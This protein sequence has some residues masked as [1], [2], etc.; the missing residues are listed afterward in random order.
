MQPK[1]VFDHLFR[2]PE[3]RRAAVEKVRKLMPA[4][5]EVG[6]SPD[7]SAYGTEGTTE[8]HQYF[9]LDENKTSTCPY[10]DLDR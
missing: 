5:D 7:L 3:T 4:F 6:I 8:A 9:L 2:T 1:W 10:G